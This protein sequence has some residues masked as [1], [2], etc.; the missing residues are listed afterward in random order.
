MNKIT[1]TLLRGMISGALATGAMSVLMFTARKTGLMRKMPPERITE[2]V[3]DRL[4]VRRSEKSE[5][6]WSTAAHLGY[7]VA[8]GGLFAWLTSRSTS[9]RLPLSAVKGTAFAT[10]IWALS[11]FGWIPALGILPPPHRDRRGRAGSMAAAHLLF[12]VV[13][14]LLSDGTRGLRVRSTTPALLN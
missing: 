1:A 10:A 14:G 7:G 6:V 11:Y 4:G 2:S 9:R 13:L 12:G 3:L 5:N 8:C